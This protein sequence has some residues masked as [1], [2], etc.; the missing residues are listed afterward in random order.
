MYRNFNKHDTNEDQIQEKHSGGDR[1]I[2]PQGS[3]LRQCGAGEAGGEVRR[4]ELGSAG[5]T[6][7]RVSPKNITRTTGQVRPLGQ[8]LVKLAAKARDPT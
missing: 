4:R 6:P 7:R 5:L 1:H 3:P 2:R 8:D